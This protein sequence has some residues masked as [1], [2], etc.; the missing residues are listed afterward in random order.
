MID[1]I[2]I[3]YIQ[4]VVVEVTKNKEKKQKVVAFNGRQANGKIV[5]VIT[6]N[7]IYT[8]FYL[9]D[10][11]FYRYLIYGDSFKNFEVPDGKS[12]PGSA[13]DP[14]IK[15]STHGPTLKFIQG[16]E[17]SELFVRCVGVV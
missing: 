5:K 2:Q 7:G 9:R 11:K 8:N 4:R 12:C 17:N 10:N 3:H 14:N 6:R 13:N 16:D 15:F 1:D